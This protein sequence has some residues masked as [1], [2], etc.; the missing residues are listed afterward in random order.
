MYET[1]ISAMNLTFD[2]EE[3]I[4]EW[5]SNLDAEEYE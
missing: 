3:E 1:F 4:E 2:D 5:L